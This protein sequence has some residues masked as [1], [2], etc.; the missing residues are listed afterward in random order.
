MFRSYRKYAAVSPFHL[1]LA[2][3]LIGHA[4]WIPSAA[5][6]EGKDRIPPGQRPVENFPLLYF[7]EVPD[8]D[9]ERWRLRVHGL[10]LEES[11]LD[12]EA[13]SS[14]D[15]VA[16]V[17]DFHCVTGWSRLD[18]SWSGV[19]IREILH[20]AGVRPEA[21]FVTFRGADGY[22][23]SLPISECAGDKDILAFRWEGILLEK[24]RGG[25]VRA[26]IPAKYAYKSALWVVEMELTEKQ[27]LG[28]FELRGYSN[29]A[30]PWKEERYEK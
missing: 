27:E 24:D 17:S 7:D 19:R 23:T 5:G 8:L 16:T 4:V 30:D 11:K 9:R 15:T 26:V 2:F 1:V 10:V 12:W 21:R 13:F 29:S 22:S 18:N 14:L 3:L 28:Y 6:G 25:P 20:R